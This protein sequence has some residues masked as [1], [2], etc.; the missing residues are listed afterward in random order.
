MADNVYGDNSLKMRTFYD[1]MKLVKARE[2]TDDK[3]RFN[4]KKTT[5]TADLVAAVAATIE[6]DLL[7]CVQSLVKAFGMSAGTIFN[8][9]HN[10]LGLIKKSTRWVPKLLSPDQVEKRVEISAAFI[11]LVQEMGRGILS[12]IVMMDESAVSMHTP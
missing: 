12:R 10:I 8:I 3:W 9:I 2:N 6:E 4:P 11:R 1:I 5:R 7:I